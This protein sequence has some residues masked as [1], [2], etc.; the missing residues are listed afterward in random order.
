MSKRFNTSQLPD[1]TD[2]RIVD[3]HMDARGLHG[4]SRREF[5]AFST[6][7]ALAAA[8]GGTLGASGMAIAATTG[9]MAHLQMSLQLEYVV[10]ADA[11]AQGAHIRH[12]S[13]GLIA[14][15]EAVVRTS[16]REMRSRMSRS[17]LGSRDVIAAV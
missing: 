8:V 15:C 11:G 3:R 2:K 4:V 9:K 14:R 5:L 12:R 16:G 7:S 6:A 10:N 13:H 17:G 1:F